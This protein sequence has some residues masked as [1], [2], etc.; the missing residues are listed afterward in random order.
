MYVE[1][2]EDAK[3][4]EMDNFMV[5]YNFRAPEIYASAQ[6]K[7]VAKSMDKGR[8]P[9]ALHDEADVTKLKDFVTSRLKTLTAE[10][11]LTSP[12]YSLLRSLVVCRL[13]LLNGSRGE[14]PARMLLSEWRDARDGA[15]LRQH[16]VSNIKV[17][18][19]QSVP[20]Q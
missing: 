16:K 18:D 17:K 8:R 19:Y 11:S 6:Y 4:V 2:M 1:S 15:W 20:R 10:T 5:T 12:N 13:T 3:V 14:E 9:A 7:V